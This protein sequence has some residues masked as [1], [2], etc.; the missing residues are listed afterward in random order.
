MSLLSVANLSVDLNGRSVLDEVSFDVEPGEFVGLIGPNGA[1]KTSLLRAVLQLIPG[2][3]DILLQG[4]GARALRASQRAKLVAYLPQ[5]R[6]IAWDVPVEM[7][8][9]LGRAPHTRGGAAMSDADHAIVDAA[10]QRMDII[11]L[12]DRPVTQLSGGEKARVLIARALAQDSALLLADEPTAGLDPAH[13][14]AVARLFSELAAQGRGVIASMHDLALAARWCTRV[15]V[16]GGGRVIADGKPADVLSDHL[17]KAVYG[18]RV[19][20]TQSDG[21]PLIYPI[22]IAGKDHR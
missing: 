5:D 19:H 13:Q 7:V 17:L 9:G 14:I 4:E 10:M 16:L 3:S 22:D 8:V 1:G 6:D 12:R 11:A 2:R 15:I 21:A 20:R 18:I